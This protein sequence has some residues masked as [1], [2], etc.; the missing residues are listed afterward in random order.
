MELVIRLLW[1]KNVKMIW[2]INFFKRKTSA[3]FVFDR[4][5]DAMSSA[6]VKAEAS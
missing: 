2:F 3:L 5:L 1:D 4:K 6:A